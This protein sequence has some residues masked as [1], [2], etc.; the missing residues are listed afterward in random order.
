M[1]PLWDPFHAVFDR[2]RKTLDALYENYNSMKTI[3]RPFISFSHMLSV[4]SISMLVICSRLDVYWNNIFSVL[5]LPSRCFSLQYSKPAKTLKWVPRIRTKMNTSFPWF[6][7][8]LTWSGRVFWEGRPQKEH[9]ET[10][11]K[12]HES[13]SG[14]HRSRQPWRQ[15]F[16]CG[17]R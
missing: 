17:E 13:P 4:E 15:L 7:M 8:N 14:P 3:C 6:P 9:K 5:C 12:S 2:C 10:G 1:V 11:N 16:F